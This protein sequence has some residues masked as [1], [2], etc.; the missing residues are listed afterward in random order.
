[1][2][3]KNNSGTC[4]IYKI[5]HKDTGRAYIGLSENIE[6]RWYRHTHSPSLKHSYIDRAIKKHGGDK[7]HLEIIEEFPNDRDLLMKREAY[8]VEYYNTYK[9]DFHYNL[10]PGGDFNPSKVPDIA[11]KISAARKGKKHSEETRK[12]ISKAMS[13]RKLS[14]ETK[15]RLSKANS[16]KNHPM[17]SK[18][19]PEET[20]KKISEANKGKKLPEETRRKMSEAHK[21]KK[22]SEEA[23]KKMSHAR[24]TTGFFHVNK[25]KC[26]TC[27]QGFTYE[28]LY[29]DDDGK[30]RSISSVDLEVLEKK[31]KAKGLTWLKFKE[32]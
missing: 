32:E 3:M 2:T 20:R 6:D 17:Y 1:M 25:R 16:G 10:T 14:Q 19:L 27:K 24:N 5:T 21:G 4:G 23:R 12:K 18:K 7:F 13:G 22:H 15:E 30:K 29:C 11:K 28:Y 9:D 26:L 31:V 8:W